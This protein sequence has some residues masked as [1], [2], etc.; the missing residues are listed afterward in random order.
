VDES[1]EACNEFF[2]MLDELQSF[3][4]SPDLEVAE[5]ESET[6]GALNAQTVD[7]GSLNDVHSS[8]D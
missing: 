2:A 1:E 6:I 5:K 3:A 8:I 4:S 7:H